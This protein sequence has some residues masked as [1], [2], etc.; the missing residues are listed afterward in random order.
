MMAWRVRLLFSSF[1]VLS[2]TLLCFYLMIV[3][4]YEADYLYIC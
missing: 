1:L 3:L 4:G 2:I